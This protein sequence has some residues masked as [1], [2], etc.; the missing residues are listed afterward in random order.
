LADIEYSDDLLL[1]NSQLKALGLP[2][3]HNHK[4]LFYWIE[5]K[6][7]I[8]EGQ[9]DFILH[10]DDLVALAD[11]DHL[12]SSLLSSFMNVG[13]FFKRQKHLIPTN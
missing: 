12:E 13:V 6:K 9:D 8:D 2:L 3:K 4:S 11:I 1:K 10:Q 5:G 7:P